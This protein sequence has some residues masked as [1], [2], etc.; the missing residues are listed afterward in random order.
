M[1]ENNFMQFRDLAQL[2]SVQ[3]IDQKHPSSSDENIVSFQAEV[4][5]AIQLAMKNFIEKYPNWDQ[6]RLVQAA[7]AGFLVQ[8]GVNSRSVTRLYI[9]NMF[10]SH[11]F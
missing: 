4:P 11:S 5:K 9:G 10:G 2:D 7:L 6:Y 8:N 3:K 1:F